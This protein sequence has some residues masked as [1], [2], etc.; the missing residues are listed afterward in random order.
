MVNPTWFLYTLAT[1]NNDQQ[2][3]LF[4][5]LA[6]GG[7][8]RDEEGGGLYMATCILRCFV[9]FKIASLYTVT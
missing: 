3:G 8:N 9:N 2:Q 7:Q 1:H 6:K 5:K 4:G